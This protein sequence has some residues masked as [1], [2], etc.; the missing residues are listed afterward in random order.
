VP[1]HLFDSCTGVT[2]FESLFR[3]CTNLQGLPAEIFRYNTLVTTMGGMF[4]SCKNLASIP[5]DLVRYNTALTNVGAFF[6]QAAGTAFSN[7]PTNFLKYNTNITTFTYS[8]YGFLES[9]SI[10]AFSLRIGSTKVSTI[11]YFCSKNTSYTRTVYVPSGSTTYTTFYNKRT[12][13]G[14]TVVAE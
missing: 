9:A 3:N 7:F 10:G 5:E 4:W 8:S 14:L 2:N 12:S 6:S 1:E 11:N 13:F